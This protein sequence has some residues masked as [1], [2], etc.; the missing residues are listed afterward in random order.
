MALHILFSVAHSNGIRWLDYCNAIFD[1]NFVVKEDIVVI[2]IILRLESFL[3]RED[4]TFR[5]LLCCLILVWF[6]H[7]EHAI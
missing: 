3:V 1:I 2:G 6:V 7:I 5:V 4:P